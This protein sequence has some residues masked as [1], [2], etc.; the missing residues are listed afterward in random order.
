M[1]VKGKRLLLS[2]IEGSGT[3]QGCHNI[4]EQFLHL[5]TIEALC[6]KKSV[7]KGQID[8]IY[9]IFS[10]YIHMFVAGISVM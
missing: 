5:G 2:S 7:K 1:K 4:K 10:N 6:E 9:C 8:G 3:N